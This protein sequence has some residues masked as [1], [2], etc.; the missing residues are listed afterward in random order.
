MTSS[1]SWS[2]RSC[3]S[4]FPSSLLHPVAG[5]IFV[6]AV[7]SWPCGSAYL[8]VHPYTQTNP[9]TILYTRLSSWL[10]LWTTDQD[11]GIFHFLPSATDKWT[12]FP[13]EIAPVVPLMLHQVHYTASWCSSVP[14]LS[15]GLN[16]KNTG[17]SIGPHSRYWL[18]VSL[19]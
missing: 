4:S 13:S 9:A 8:G 1:Q 17:A 6:K 15:E 3:P 10:Q 19:G 11:E 5:N 2:L 18:A 14:E 7:I 12:S 16:R